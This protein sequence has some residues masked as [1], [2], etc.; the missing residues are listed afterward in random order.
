MIL[1]TPKTY[2]ITLLMTCCLGVAQTG[3][4]AKTFSGEIM[5][6]LCAKNKSHDKMM[7]QMKSM[8]TNSVVCSQKCVEMGAHY[9]LYDRQK[10]AIYKLD[11]PEKAAPF[12]GKTVSISGT[13][14]K[15]KIKIASIEATGPA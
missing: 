14:D 8:G 1:K 3:S 11:N 4:A 7:Q 2:L 9:V 6:D 13:L 5:D 10:D 15:N 12:A